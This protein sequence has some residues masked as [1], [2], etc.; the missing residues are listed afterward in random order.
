MSTNRLLSERQNIE[1]S[2]VEGNS[3]EVDEAVPVVQEHVLP[4]EQE[5]VHLVPQEH[6]PSTQGDYV[7]VPQATYTQVVV[8]E[9]VQTLRQDSG[10]PRRQM[11]TLR[12]DQ[13]RTIRNDFVKNLRQDYDRRLV[14][15]HQTSRCPSNS[16]SG[17]SFLHAAEI[18]VLDTTVESNLVLP[19]RKQQMQ[20]LLNMSVNKYLSSE[21]AKRKREREMAP[22]D[23]DYWNEL[24]EYVKQDLKKRDI[25][26]AKEPNNGTDTVK[27]NKPVKPIVSEQEAPKVSSSEDKEEELVSIQQIDPAVDEYKRLTNITLNE[28][29][30][31]LYSL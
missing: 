21:L 26:R 1:Q 11:Q 2:V 7:T 22:T 31:S 6:I 4:I 28:S 23:E 18:T 14:M 12:R 10:Q 9:E 24:K 15:M 30:N 29:R 5:H 19:P 8:Q 27:I 17:Q 3:Q 25:D 13:I 20:Q 16:S